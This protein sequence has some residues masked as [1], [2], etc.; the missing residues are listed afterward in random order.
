MAILACLASRPSIGVAWESPL[1]L[2]SKGMGYG[3]Q[4]WKGDR[5]SPRYSAG[6]SCVDRSGTE[7]QG[8]NW[9]A[10]INVVSIRLAGSNWKP[11]HHSGISVPYWQHAAGA[12]RVEPVGTA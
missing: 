1:Q 12:V 9:R 11:M 5:P 10:E 3:S 8:S 7:E 6:W 4:L 2:V